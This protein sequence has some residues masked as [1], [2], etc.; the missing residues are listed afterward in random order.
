MT[1][2]ETEANEAAFEELVAANPARLDAGYRD[3]V[4]LSRVL[5]SG[6]DAVPARRSAP[7][8]AGGAVA[9][10]A[11]AA[12]IGVAVTRSG[13]GG[14]STTATPDVAGTQDT[15]L[16]GG[17]AAL[18]VE[19][20]SPETLRNRQFAFDGTV[21]SISGTNATFSVNRAYKGDVGDTI[22]LEAGG[23]LA[24]TSVNEEGTLEVGGRYLVSGDDTFL[25][26]CGFSQPYSEELAGEWEAALE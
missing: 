19:L 3:P 5:A 22:T 9:T 20:Y 17:F 23:M 1:R 7:V 14:S 12:V 15:E 11:V 26:T 6:P 4:L 18:C 21:E 13:G 2:N 25:W 24:I 16:G 10:L 8:I